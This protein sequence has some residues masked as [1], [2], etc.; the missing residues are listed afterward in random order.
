MFNQ[1]GPTLL[2]SNERT[3]NPISPLTT[4]RNS[5]YISQLKGTLFPS[6]IQVNW[7]FGVISMSILPS[8]LLMFY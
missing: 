5:V 2:I 6:G 1:V 4:Q 7:M 8:R 3:T